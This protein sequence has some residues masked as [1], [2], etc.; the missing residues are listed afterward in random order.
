M[1]KA[2]ILSRIDI[3]SVVAGIKPVLAEQL[4]HVVEG[5]EADVQA[6]AQGIAT[7][8]SEAIAIGAEALTSELEHQAHVLLEKQNVR[9]IAAKHAAFA[10]I[11]N[12]AVKL[13]SQ[14]IAIAVAAVGKIG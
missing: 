2:D 9:L 14:G 7:D 5:A 13:V 10:S 8:L 11:L 3:G 6:F 1:D 4:S 12:G